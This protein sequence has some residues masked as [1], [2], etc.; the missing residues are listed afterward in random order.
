M[1]RT[2]NTLSRELEL[3]HKCTVRER[4]DPERES[5]ILLFTD[6]ECFEHG[7][8][9]AKYSISFAAVGGPLHRIR[10]T[11]AGH[12]TESDLLLLATAPNQFT[13]AGHNT[14]SD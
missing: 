3:L 1:K 7:F 4:S 8:E 14:K 13:A 10:F 6:F 11:A 12:N 9:F 2:R 5:C